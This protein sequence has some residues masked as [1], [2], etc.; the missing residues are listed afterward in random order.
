M[1]IKFKDSIP[2]PGSLVILVPSRFLKVKKKEP[3]KVKRFNA[4]GNKQQV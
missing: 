4:K 3:V 2:L 1:F